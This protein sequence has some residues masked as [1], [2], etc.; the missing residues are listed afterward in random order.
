[1]D[2]LQTRIERL[3]LWRNRLLLAGDTEYAEVVND[4]LH[5]IIE[6]NFSIAGRWT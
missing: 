1:M 3:I 6:Y 4:Y 5:R 2:T